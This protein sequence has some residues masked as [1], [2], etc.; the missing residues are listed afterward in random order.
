MI[1]FED[2]DSWSGFLERRGLLMDEDARSYAEDAIVSS[3]IDD[4]HHIIQTKEQSDRQLKH[5][6]NN[7]AKRRKKI[8]ELIADPG[9]KVDTMVG[10][11]VSDGIHVDILF[12]WK[13]SS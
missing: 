2:K 7:D 10:V 4:N 3:S 6:K 11:L 12:M 8:Q 9:I 1:P 13:N 5:H